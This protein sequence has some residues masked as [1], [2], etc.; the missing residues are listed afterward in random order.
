MSNEASD[1]PLDTLLV[2]SQSYEDPDLTAL[3]VN[4]KITECRCI[5]GEGLPRGAM[6][7]DIFLYCIQNEFFGH[8][9]STSYGSL[10]A[11]VRR[12]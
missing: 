3:M 10:H 12:R 7:D 8:D 5:Q 9:T 11:L 6:T 1:L 4:A 2:A